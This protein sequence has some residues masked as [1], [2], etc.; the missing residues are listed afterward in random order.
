MAEPTPDS[1]ETRRLLRQIEAGELAA[2]DRLFARHRPELRRFI[3]LRLDSRLRARVDPSDVAQETH[4][5]AY[6]R[7]PDYLQRKPMPF[8]LWLRKTAYER[9]L[10]LRRQHLHAFDHPHAPATRTARLKGPSALGRLLTT[11]SH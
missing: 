2:F 10:M 1:D 7:L 6:R 4:L 9:L 3:D 5:E 8:R 11:V